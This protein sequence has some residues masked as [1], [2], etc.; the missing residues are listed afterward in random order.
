MKDR[1]DK[2]NGEHWP[3]HFGGDG[4]RQEGKIGRGR[5]RMVENGYGGGHDARHGTWPLFGEG[6]MEGRAARDQVRGPDKGREMAKWTRK[7]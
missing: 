5:E 3:G 6:T 4:P 1:K 2:V 7:E